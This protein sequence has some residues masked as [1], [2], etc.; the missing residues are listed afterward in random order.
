MLTATQQSVSLNCSNWF[1]C[2]RTKTTVWRLV[3]CCISLI[4]GFNSSTFCVLKVKTPC[5]EC[6]CFHRVVRRQNS[7]PLWRRTRQRYLQLSCSQNFF[8]PSY[9]IP[10]LWGTFALHRGFC[11]ARLTFI[12]DWIGLEF[13]SR[14][15]PWFVQLHVWFLQPWKLAHFLFD[16]SSCIHSA[17][18]PQRIEKI[19]DG[20]LLS[21]SCLPQV[22]NCVRRA[23]LR[24]EIVYVP[25]KTPKWLSINPEPFTLFL[26]F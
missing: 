19:S 21:M 12:R 18:D 13:I 15:P 24:C 1:L 5:Y 2:E 17:H 16:E 7:T 22:E 9:H 11:F 6:L 20:R 3:W 4:T 14:K 8:H 10:F 23:R 26:I 25:S